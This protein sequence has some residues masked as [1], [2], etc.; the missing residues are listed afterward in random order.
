MHGLLP[1]DR[2]SDDDRATTA[3]MPPF[4]AAVGGEA[5][6]AAR[7]RA[8]SAPLSPLVLAS[9]VIMLDLVAIGGAGLIADALLGAPG[10]RHAATTA[11]VAG[12][13]VAFGGALG[14]Y[15]HG[16]LF[17][18]A[19]Q[20]TLA[21]QG[22]AAALLVAAMAGVTFGASEAV[23]PAWLGLA[24]LLGGISLLGGRSAVGILLRQD[25]TRA[26]QRAVVVGTGPQA[27]RLMEAM[28]REGGCGL[29]LLGVVDDRAPRGAPPPRGGMAGL[30]PLGGMAS[31]FAMI[32]AGEVEVVV[33]AA[34]W[35]AEARI[36]ELLE[37][38]SPF[39]VEIRLAPDLLSERLPG[40]PAGPVLLRARPISGLGG[41][42]KRAEDYA[43]ALAALAI[44]AVPM[45]LIALAIR[46]DSPGPVLFRQKR[47]G[48][49]D[50]PFDV[51]KFRTLYAE[52]T[53]HH[54]LRQV[55]PGDPRVTPVGAIL[56]RTSLDELPQ[57]FN[58]LRGDMSF[59]GPR[60]HAPG[61]RAGSRRFDEV[62]ANYAARHRVKPGLTGLAQ[63]RG[64]RG[65][66][67]TEEQLVRRV[68]SDLEY[69]ETWSLWLD[70]KIILRTLLAV[71]CMR[72][73]L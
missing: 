57:I 66:T 31:L 71:A 69:I 59:V 15:D 29:R 18:A 70:L 12:L 42:V 19:R 2:A 28:R 43:C 49:N 35:A 54:A 11:L 6:A 14:A 52:A 10:A 55:G 65:P 61:T 63:V 39:P 27:N 68:E 16:V 13:A 53:D 36:A 26:L 24:A 58:V 17:Q 56:R 45:L 48:F 40:R 21:L 7:Q 9:L 50:R 8:I 34:P 38:L 41:A 44:A 51:L 62:V 67:V 47:T 3:E 20:R 30:R 33:I 64:W 1:P 23:E 37:A 72:N 60:P 73:A 46:L 32:R 4:L 22:A 5:R 25:G